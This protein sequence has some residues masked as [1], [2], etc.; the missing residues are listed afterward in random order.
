MAITYKPL[1]LTVNG[2]QIGPMEVPVGLSMLDFL[3]E[4]LDL[5]GTRMSCGQGICHAC[6][7][8]LDKPDGTSE[9]HRTCITGAHFFEGKKI[10]TIEGIAEKEG[11]DDEKEKLS[12]IQQAFVDNFAFQCGYCAPGFVNA[13]TVFVEK[14]MREPIAKADLE[15]SIM[16]ALD[17]HICRCTG[18]VRYYDAVKNVVLNTP[19]LLKD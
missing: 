8:I 1:S 2:E 16:D 9:S 11:S 15:Q 6:V 3:H 14:L 10:R 5:T 7:L 18:Y 4:Y 17:P 19:G 13:T 12:Q